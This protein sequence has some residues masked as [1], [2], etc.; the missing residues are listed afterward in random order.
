MKSDNDKSIASQLFKESREVM[1]DP[2]VMK[3]PQ[4]WFLSVGDKIEKME[5][6]KKLVEEQ[7]RTREAIDLLKS[8]TGVNSQNFEKLTSSFKEVIDIVKGFNII[9]DKGMN[10]FDLHGTFDKFLKIQGFI[11]E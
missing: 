10:M 1:V 7:E 4:F 5:E 2:L 6:Y 9:E 3:Q 11:N 8:S